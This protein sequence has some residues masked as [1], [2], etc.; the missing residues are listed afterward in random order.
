TYEV[1]CRARTGKCSSRRH[2]AT[3]SPV[4]RHCETLV[5]PCCKAMRGPTTS[6]DIKFSTVVMLDRISKIHKKKSSL[7]TR[8][9]FAL[10]KKR[11]GASHSP[12]PKATCPHPTR[13]LRPPGRRAQTRLCTSQLWDATETRKFLQK[14]SLQ[15][16][17]A[18]LMLSGTLRR[19]GFDSMQQDEHKGFAARCVLN[20]QRHIVVRDVADRAFVNSARNSLNVDS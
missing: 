17:S 13:P 3:I 9:N 2:C 11:A 4:F 6:A 20:F 19:D 15:I 18:F 16:T 7:L 12:H 8:R 10:Q 5:P 14:I 1:S